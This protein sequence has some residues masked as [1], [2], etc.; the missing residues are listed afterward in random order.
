MIMR[1]VQRFAWPAVGFLAV[2]FLGAEFAVGAP[3]AT[4]SAQPAGVDQVQG[5]PLFE[6]W[7]QALE[8]K[9]TVGDALAAAG[10]LAAACGADEALRTATHKAHLAR[11][12]LLASLHSRG[13]APS[14]PPAGV[15]PWPWSA[16]A[17][18]TPTISDFDKDNVSVL[19]D[20][21]RMVYIN[22][23]AVPEVDGAFASQTFYEKHD[24]E[25]EFVVL[26]TDFF[27]DLFNGSFRAYHLAVQNDVAGLGYQNT[28][29]GDVF[30]ERHLY[31]NN[32]DPNGVLQSFLHLNDIR[33][34]PEDPDAT[35]L[36]SYSATA[37]ML[38]EFSHRWT[39][40]LRLWLPIYGPQPVLLGRANVHWSFF[41]NAGGSFNEGVQWV[42]EGDGFRT[43]ASTSTFGPL[44]LYLMGL[45]QPS[46]VDESKL[47]FL[48]EPY[49]AQPPLDALNQPWNAWSPPQNDVFMRGRRVDFDMDAVFLAN[50]VRRP[51]PGAAPSTFRAATLLVIPATGS[52]DVDAEIAKINI[53]QQN[54]A[55]R[56]RNETLQRGTLDLTVHSVPARLELLHQPQGNVEQAGT[57]VEIVTAIELVQRSLPTTVDQIQATLFYRIDAGPETAVVMQRGVDDLFRAVIPGQS[58]GTQIDYWIRANSGQ[59]GYEYTLPASAPQTRLSFQIAPDV[60]APT[61]QHI[62]VTRHARAAEAL[63]VRAL[64]RDTH[65]V[66]S[67]YCEYQLN[68]GNWM[69]A[70]LL[71]QG[72]SDLFEARVVLPGRIGDDIDYRIIA[73]D[74][75]QSVHV[76]TLPAAGTWKLQITESVV[77]DAERED[78]LWTHYSVKKNAEDQWHREPTNRTPGGHWCWKLGP[79][80]V[81][82]IPRAGVMN[83]DMDAALQT[84]AVRLSPGWSLSFFHRYYLRLS[85]PDTDL[86]AVDGALIEW[87][88]IESSQDVLDNRWYPIEPVGGYP[89][90]LTNYAY[91][92]PLKGANCWAGQMDL[93]KPET[94]DRS[95]TYLSLSNRMVRFR[96]RCATTPIIWY[97]R[98]GAGWY[99]DDITLYPGPGKTA[100]TLTDVRASRIAEGIELRWSAPDVLAGESFVV[101]RLLPGGPSSWQRVAR[102]QGEVDRSDYTYMD[103]A[104]PRVAAVHYRVTLLRDGIEIASQIL[105]VETVPAQFRLAQNTPNPFNPQTRINFELPQS[106]IATLTIYDVRGRRVRSL[107]AEELHAGPHARTWD[108]T[109]DDGRR[110][111]S[112]VYLYHLSTR[113]HAATNRML[114][115]Q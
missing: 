115:L 52:T 92:N 12:Q 13:L 96:F 59:A 54:L 5:D 2:L 14:P 26:F 10:G 74:A 34:Y 1:P 43:L 66:G 18:V 21:G 86:S 15:A 68:G 37:F 35:Y 98:P 29:L 31:T 65:A 23:R 3:Q 75:A 94:F 58:T 83:L 6:T 72:V 87:Q 90:R 9:Q 22:L 71:R 46:E 93:W 102:V 57:D 41:A 67:A 108:G 88:D 62:P 76:S 38:H 60:V 39:N 112:G 114:L 85:P 30:S 32:S 20:D 84:I 97:D 44:D 56:F 53:Y 69:R 100:V 81:S 99:V 48:E 78:P 73:M 61:I 17:G 42:P 95:G 19:V 45:L 104:A 91:F 64:V 47:F 82:G 103:E 16:A 109:D 51:L 11:V 70:D 113:L 107:V 40:R 80:N 63:L 24:D 105:Q 55:D 36:R 25:Y 28:S 4:V 79:D 33:L 101:D 50:G 110:V 89:Y 49:D 7:R 111:A 8:E 77:Q 27:S 106:G